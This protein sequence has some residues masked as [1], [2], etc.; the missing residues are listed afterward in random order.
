MPADFSEVKDLAVD[1]GKAQADTVKQSQQAVVKTTYDIE[2][3]G[4]R[5]AA[6]DTGAMRGSIGSDIGV[7]RSVIGPTVNYAPHVEHGT[8]RMPPQPF[9]GPAADR[10][11]PEFYR[12][13][14]IIAGDIL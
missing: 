2:A 8:S 3:T 12:A 5:L 4:K 10:H 1:L 6:V 11:A 13:M 9:M 14:G 7:L